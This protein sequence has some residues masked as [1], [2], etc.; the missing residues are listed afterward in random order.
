[1]S[2]HT[3]SLLDK[4][5]VFSRKLS[6]EDIAYEAR[7]LVLPFLLAVAACALTISG[8]TASAPNA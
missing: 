5:S 8:V 2:G 3:A 1:M 7:V 6:N 4:L